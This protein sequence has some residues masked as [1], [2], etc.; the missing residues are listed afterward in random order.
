[1]NG[2][3]MTEEEFEEE[4]TLAADGRW[5]ELFSDF[6]PATLQEFLADA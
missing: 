6:K 2:P 5:N 4:L 1:M 3:L